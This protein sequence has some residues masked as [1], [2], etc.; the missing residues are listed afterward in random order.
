MAGAR[1]RKKEEAILRKYKVAILG[2]G[3]RG[4]DFSRFGKLEGA[5]N[6]EPWPWV[7]QAANSG[8]VEFSFDPLG[9]CWI[10]MMNS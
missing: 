5:N 6:G 1:R 10:A 7:G 8:L 2:L 3:S 9:I 4:R